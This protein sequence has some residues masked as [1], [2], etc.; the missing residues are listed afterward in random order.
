MHRSR[1]PSLTLF[2]ILKVILMTSKHP[3][4][5]INLPACFS[6]QHWTL[7]SSEFPPNSDIN[8]RPNPFRLK[9]SLMPLQVTSRMMK[10]GTGWGLKRSF[11]MQPLMGFPYVVSVCHLNSIRPAKSG[12]AGPSRKHLPSEFT[13]QRAGL[14]L[15]DKITC[16][17]LVKGQRLQISD[18]V[19]SP[20]ELSCK[21]V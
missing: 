17:S 21:D 9:A 11:L 6:F 5:M 16:K 12:E 8:R 19:Y 14:Q 7:H 4:D 10:Y 18:E 15:T 2:C 20:G 1:T 3:P 13:L